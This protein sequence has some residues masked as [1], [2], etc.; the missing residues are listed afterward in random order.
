MPY[1]IAV[2][3]EKFFLDGGVYSPLRYFPHTRSYQK[4]GADIILIASV[5]DPL[6]LGG[7]I[8]CIYTPGIPLGVTII[9]YI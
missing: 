1:Y 4:V 3:L 9:I 2:R 6:L 7:G 5:G 8:L